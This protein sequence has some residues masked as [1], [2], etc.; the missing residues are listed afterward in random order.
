MSFIPAESSTS[1]KNVGTDN[2][3]ELAAYLVEKALVEV[4]NEQ[5]KSIAKAG[6]PD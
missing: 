1:A 4:R 6:P 2:G 5:P 3:A